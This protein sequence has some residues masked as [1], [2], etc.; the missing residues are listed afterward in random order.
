MRT[1]LITGASSGIGAEGPTGGEGTFLNGTM[2]RRRSRTY[3]SEYTGSL[4]DGIDTGEMLHEFATIPQ[5]I[6]D[7]SA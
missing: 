1:A 5:V 2:R 4:Q 3:A 7:I 6:E